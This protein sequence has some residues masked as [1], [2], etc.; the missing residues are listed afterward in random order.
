GIDFDLA[1]A[2]LD[3]E[4]ADSADRAKGDLHSVDGAVVGE[5]LLDQRPV[6]R[7]GH[8]SL[9]RDQ[10]E[11]GRA[12]AELQSPCNIVC[13]LLL[14][15]K[16]NSLSISSTVFETLSQNA[17]MSSVKPAACSISTPTARSYLP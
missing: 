17:T 12:H 10:S 5:F 13:R 6:R 2:A 14:E 15:K 8:E 16:K 11:I 3:V 7:I 1:D 9:F 4:V